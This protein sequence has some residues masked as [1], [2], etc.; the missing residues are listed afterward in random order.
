MRYGVKLRGK[1]REVR[2]KV[3]K[4]DR[5]AVIYEVTYLGKY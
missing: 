4:W 3:K 1:L 2:R 5:Y